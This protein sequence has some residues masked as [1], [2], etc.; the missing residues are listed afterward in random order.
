MNRQTN[1]KATNLSVITDK[2]G[3]CVTADAS[4][5]APEFAAALK[6]LA[7]PVNCERSRLEPPNLKSFKT[8][9][10]KAM[11]AKAYGWELAELAALQESA[12]TERS[13]FGMVRS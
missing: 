5:P 6:A 4:K 11:I 2:H 3:T 13:A 10:A 8:D 7:T 9:E 1:I 12:P